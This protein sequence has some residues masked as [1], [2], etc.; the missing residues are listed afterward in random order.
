MY[1]SEY[2]MQMRKLQ[3]LYPYPMYSR[4][5]IERKLVAMGFRLPKEV[6]QLNKAITAEYAES[7]KE[8]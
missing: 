3:L 5:D 7:D 2:Q 4:A 1:Y 6:V 8:V